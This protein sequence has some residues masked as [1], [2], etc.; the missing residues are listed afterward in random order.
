MKSKFEYRILPNSNCFLTNSMAIL[1]FYF[2]FNFYFFELLNS[3][4][5]LFISSELTF[6]VLN[7]RFATRRFTKI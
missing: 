7:T 2:N 5:N 6:T 4:V 3:F 1:F